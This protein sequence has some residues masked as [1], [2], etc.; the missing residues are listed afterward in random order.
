MPR[1][2][3]FATAW[4]ILCHHRGIQCH[5][6]FLLPPH[7]NFRAT[8]VVYQ[9]HATFFLPTREKYVPPLWHSMPH[10]YISFATY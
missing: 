8:F 3:S 4:K 9:C 2:I 10:Y 7:G 1:Y 5:A 6:T